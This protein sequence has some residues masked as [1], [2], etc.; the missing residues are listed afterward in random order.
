MVVEHNQWTVTKLMMIIDDLIHYSRDC[1]ACR[2][3]SV[4]LV[5]ES[6]AVP[7][8]DL[9]CFLMVG[10]N[11]PYHCWLDHFATHNSRKCSVVNFVLFR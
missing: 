5:F 7:M 3:A 1:F 8:N 11:H 2:F 10:P 9:L 6:S 4:L